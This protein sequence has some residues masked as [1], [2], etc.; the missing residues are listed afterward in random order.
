MYSLENRIIFNSF[1]YHDKSFK[2]NE[3]YSFKEYS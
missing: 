3:G 1:V 2:S